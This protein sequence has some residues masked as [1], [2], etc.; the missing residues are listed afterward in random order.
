[1]IIF[2]MALVGP[3]VA[4][5]LSGLG[6]ARYRFLPVAL[7]AVLIA[8]YTISVSAAGIWASRCWDCGQYDDSR[9][10]GFALAATFFTMVLVAALLGIG[11]GVVLSSLIQR[12]SQ[13]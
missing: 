3:F 7:A 2:L 10:D 4:G 11:A 12:N 1:M 8:G 9:G 5:L 6:K 13:R